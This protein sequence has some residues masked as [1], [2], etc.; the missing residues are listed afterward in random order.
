MIHR[1]DQTWQVLSWQRQLSEAFTDPDE[2]LRYLEIDKNLLPSAASAQ[3]KFS[4]RVPRWFAGRME[5]GNPNDPLLRQVLP[6]EEELLP[7]AGFLLDPVSDL[8][9]APIPGLLQKYHGR[10]LLITTG[11]CAIN[12]RYCFR[13]HYPYADSTAGGDRLSD[14]LAYLEE[15]P[16]ISEVI[17]SGG[18]P[19]MLPDHHLAELGARLEA[20]PHVRR[21]RIHTRLPVVLPDRITA[22]LTDWLAATQLQPIVVLHANHSKELSHEHRRALAPLRARGVTLLNQSVL[23]KGVNDNIQIL[24]DL[25]EKLFSVGVLPYYL[26]QLDRVAGAV[27]FEVTDAVALDLHQQMSARLPG[28]MLPRLVREKAGA[29]SK[30]PLR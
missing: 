21:L 3:R 4:L 11:A 23:L 10:A 13:R 9:Q 17:L 30:I 26:H 1:T 25:S 22:E 24:C 28:Y 29:P 15:T 12:C 6:L 16:D 27:H 19:L 20:I 14:A 18:D 5:Q 2:L 7:K 8:E